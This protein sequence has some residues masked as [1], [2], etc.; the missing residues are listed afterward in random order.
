MRE[1]EW[2]D[3]EDTNR[4]AQA[5]MARMCGWM[6]G[7]I[8]EQRE[9]HGLTDSNGGD[10]DVHK[11]FNEDDVPSNPSRPGLPFGACLRP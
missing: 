8:N 3:D 10:L 11:S 5:D 9:L 1:H 7:W 4:A 6:N 2:M